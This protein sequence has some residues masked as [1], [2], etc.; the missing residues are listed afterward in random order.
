MQASIVL[1]AELRLLQDQ[2]RLAESE[3]ATA[4]VSTAFYKALGE[5]RLGVEY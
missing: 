1:D 3:T 2:E 4:T 5:G